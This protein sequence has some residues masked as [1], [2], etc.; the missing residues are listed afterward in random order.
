MN[1]NPQVCL[2]SSVFRVYVCGLAV[3]MWFLGFTEPRS[4]FALVARIEE[5]ATILWLM[6]LFGS[7]GLFDVLANDVLR[8][9]MRCHSTRQNRHFGFSALA[10][11]YTVLVLIAYLQV[12]SPGLAAYALWNAILVIAFA[13]IDAHQ[14]SKDLTC[15][16]M[17]N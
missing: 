16:Q 9:A 7:V 3:V 14:R 13:L 1:L 6:L 10:F 12:K 5:G 2:A 17:C 4:M 8:G 15:L 11:C